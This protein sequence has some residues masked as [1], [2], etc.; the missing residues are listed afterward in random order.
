MLS[1]FA[2]AFCLVLTMAA[3]APSAAKAQQLSL[4]GVKYPAYPVDQT[5]QACSRNLRSFEYV[6][7]AYSPGGAATCV[8]GVKGLAK[9]SRAQALQDC[10]SNRSGAEAKLTKCRLVMEN[11]KI[12]DASFYKSQRRDARTPVAIEIFDGKTG[13]LSR[14]TGHLSSGRLLSRTSIEVKLTSSGGAVLCEGVMKFT[15]LSARFEATCFNSFAFSGRVPKSDGFAMY[16][17]QFVQR[18]TMKLKHEKS[19]ISIAPRI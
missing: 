1:R 9:E 13:K 16:E 19:Y 2:F 17:G 11:G 4:E 6:V 18:L 8:R 5:I 12:I 14:T 7:L 3:F 15:G 10:N